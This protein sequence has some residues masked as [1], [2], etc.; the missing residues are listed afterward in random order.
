MQATDQAKAIRDKLP[1]NGLFASHEW[2]LPVEAFPLEEKFARD[3]KQLGRVLHQFYRAAD[4]L[5]R[6]S[7]S[8]KQPAWV[9]QWLE[10]GNPTA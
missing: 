3:L 1:L 5:Y 7:V 4:L 9:A 6:H 10:R 2:R 8:G